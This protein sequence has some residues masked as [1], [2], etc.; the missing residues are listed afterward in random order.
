MELLL[1]HLH[2]DIYSQFLQIVSNNNYIS[3]ETQ[4]S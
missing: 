3:N 2:I 1:V 4:T